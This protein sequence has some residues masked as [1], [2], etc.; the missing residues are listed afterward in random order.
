[1]LKQTGIPTS[2]QVESVFPSYKRLNKGAAAVI[3]CFQN[4]PCN[5]CFT[6]CK[7]GAMK[8]FEDICDLPNI[9]HEKCNGCG[10]C[11]A[12]CP[13]LSIMVVD[14]TYSEDKALMKIP[15][16]FFPL[17]KE[18]EV[19][20]GLDRSGQYVA[21]VTVVKVQ[22]VKAFDKTQIVSIAVDKDKV[23]II[24]NIKVVE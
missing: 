24:R 17:P 18:G 13:G 4:I 15:C 12:K 21:D 19:V 23:K 7:R 20:K 10:L 8:K 5:P 14:L 16:E 11:I 6:A 22:D 2:E 3:E 1:M 9:D